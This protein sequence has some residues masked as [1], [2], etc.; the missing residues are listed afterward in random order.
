MNAVARTE[1]TR[2]L[3][4]Y[5]EL[6]ALCDQGFFPNRTQVVLLD[7]EIHVMPADGV[8]HIH[9][10]M[11][12]MRF[13]VRAVPERCFI[14][15]QTTLRLSRHNAPSP[16]LYILDGPLPEGD[17]PAANIL[18]VVEVADSS[19]KDDL[20]DSAARYARHGVREYW[21]LDVAAPALLLH[22]NPNAAAYPPPQRLEA[23]ELAE[24]LLIPE[25]RL[26]LTDLV[27]A[28]S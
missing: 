7:G 5:E 1:P 6:S 25:L 27:A 23:T 8:R 20:T 13:A 18:L 15:V 2:H 19:L 26:R 22:R 10:A 24:A 21:V 9:W 12:L 16:D 28:G 11:A 4:T 17:V 3:V 14:G